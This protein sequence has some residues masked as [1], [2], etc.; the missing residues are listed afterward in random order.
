M[1]EN[2]LVSELLSIL[3]QIKIYHWKTKDYAAHMALDILYDSFTDNVDKVVEA[4]LGSSNQL[5]Y[6]LDINLVARNDN[7]DLFL[8]LV[9]QRLLIIIPNIQH[10]PE[11][12]SV[13][14]TMI[15][16][17]D[18]CRYVCSLKSAPIIKSKL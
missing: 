8:Q 18:K 10:I 1:K 12:V 13:I 2:E 15:V 6:S 14:D 9:R 3:N 11:L 5:Q 7:I 4:Y 17:V 16:D